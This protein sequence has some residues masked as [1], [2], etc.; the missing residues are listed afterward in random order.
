MWRK[1]EADQADD[2]GGQ[3]LAQLGQE[4]PMIMGQRHAETATGN[5]IHSVCPT[6]LVAARLMAPCGEIVYP[7]IINP[8]FGDIALT[9]Y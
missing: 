5:I 1:K 9:C 3:L 6:P 8:P 2:G 7:H 4:F